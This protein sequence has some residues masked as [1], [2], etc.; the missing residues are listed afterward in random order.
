M[1]TFDPST[2]AN[3]WSLQKPNIPKLSKL[4]SVGVV[5]VGHYN[6]ILDEGKVWKHNPST[7]TNEELP[8][9]P[10]S[11]CLFPKAAILERPSGVGIMAVCTDGRT[12]FCLLEKLDLHSAATWWRQLQNVP[13]SN[14]N[15]MLAYVE[16]TMYCLRGPNAWR[17]Q[18]NSETWEAATGG[19]TAYYQNGRGTY[20]TIPKY[21]VPGC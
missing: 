11:D 12:F 1:G 6:I 18:E 17:W 14:S 13:D 4:R 9:F 8:D 2:P 3:P 10:V 7:D 5:S 19:Q 20:T 21:L 16:G 15:T